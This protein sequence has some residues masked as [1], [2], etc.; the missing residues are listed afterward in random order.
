MNEGLRCDFIY[1]PA[2]YDAGR[3]RRLGRHFVQILESIVTRPEARLHELDWF[4]RAERQAVTTDVI[5]STSLPPDQSAS[6]LFEQ[7]A[8]ATPDALAVELG[9]QRLTFAEL[10]RSVDDL[11]LRLRQSGIDSEVP[12]GLVL[13]P[14]PATLVRLLAILKAGGICVPIGT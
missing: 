14:V 3:I 10:A 13:D 5:D 11:A 7:H 2:L 12:V 1:S 9:D 6:D 8:G 4:T